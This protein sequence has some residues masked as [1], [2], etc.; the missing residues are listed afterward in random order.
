MKEQNGWLSRRDCLKLAGAVALATPLAGR[1]ADDLRA[2]AKKNLK[3][4]IFTGVYAGLPLEEAAKR[5]KADGFSG[6]VLEGNFA[7]VRFDPFAPDWE[8]ANKITGTLDRNG[9]KVVGL[10]GYYNVVAPNAENRKRGE[11]RMQFLIENWKR[12]GS[13][14]ISTETGSRNAES[15][16]NDSPENATEAAYQQC[17][18]SLEKF[19]RMAEKTGAVISIEA[20]W[21]NVIGSAERTERLFNDVKSPALKLVMDP[22]NYFRKAELARMQPMLK[23]IFQRVGKQ[24]VIAHAK[25]VKA[26]ANADDTE[27]PAAGKGVLDYPLYLRLLAELDRE[28]YLAVEHLALP[29]VPAARD[30]VLAQFEKI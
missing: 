17:R 27:L 7:D 1:A 8:A 4:A 10:Y 21:K 5:I 9:I 24:T 29:E 16:W 2:R 3:L 6:A 23:D 28:I 12:L 19:A 18:T 25:D 22:C 11:Q 13:N 30:Y 14:N 20:Y 15:E 26:A